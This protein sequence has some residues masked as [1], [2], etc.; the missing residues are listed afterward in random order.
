[1]LRACDAGRERIEECGIAKPASHRRKL[2]I[3]LAK[4]DNL[5]RANGPDY[6]RDIR[7]LIHDHNN[8]MIR[9]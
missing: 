9:V 7:I 2:S 5:H 4:P 1:M 8:G 6:P 3:Y